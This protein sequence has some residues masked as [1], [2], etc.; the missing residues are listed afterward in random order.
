[1]NFTALLVKLI[2]IEQAVGVETN[3]AIRRKMQDVQDD[4]L[5]MQ[6]EMASDLQDE[7]SHFVTHKHLIPSA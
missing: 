2:Q 7:R 6:K 5:Q 1:M 3:A 4:V